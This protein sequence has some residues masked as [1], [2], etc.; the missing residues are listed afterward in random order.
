MTQLLVSI[1]YWLFSFRFPCKQHKFSTSGMFFS[2]I[3]C[4]LSRGVSQLRWFGW[5]GKKRLILT[6]LGNTAAGSFLISQ[7]GTNERSQEI[8]DRR[9]H[10]VKYHDYHSINT[11]YFT[12]KLRRGITKS[13]IK[14]CSP[15]Q[16]NTLSDCGANRRMG[17]YCR[18][19]F[20]GLRG[21]ESPPRN[22]GR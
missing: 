8:M 3:F 16:L 10:L 15:L 21:A 1:D 6:F 13:H 7:K 22:F 12:F 14:P 9:S 5:G 20:L 18:L 11:N 19:P 4:D 2:S 17:F